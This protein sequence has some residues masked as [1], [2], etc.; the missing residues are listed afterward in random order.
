M[1]EEQDQS[2]KTEEPT[3]KKLEDAHKKGDVVKSREVGHWFMLAAMALAILISAEPVARTLTEVFVGILGNAY[4]IAV[5]RD[6]MLD[7]MAFLM[8]TVAGAF[9]VPVILFITAALG[10]TLVQ[11]K[12]VFTGE[13][14]KPDLSKISPLKGFKR[15]FSSQ[16][17]MEFLKTLAKFIIVASVVALVIAPEAG[18]LEQIAAYDVASLLPL[19]QTTTLKMLVGVLA[20][21]A[22]IAGL[23]YLYQ[24]YQH[25]KK[26]RMTKQ[27]VKDEYKQTDGDPHV[28]ARL[29]QLR[30]ERSRQRMMAA[31][32]EAD[33]VVTNP[34]HFAVAMKYDGETMEAPKV[35]AKGVDHLAARIRELAEANNIPIVENPPLARA[36]YA[37]VE[38]DREIQPEHYRAVA[39]V[40]SYVM[41][42]RRKAR[43]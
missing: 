30:Q 26:M 5:E 19:V 8:I 7:L 25:I 15:L 12:P 33:V 21:M 2:Q 11:H 40:I 38:V 6:S 36:L 10:G 20:I 32:P 22:I 4:Q 39:E 29:R 31:V 3:Q 24:S 42:L 37:S 28:K 18:R 27:E 17:V 16:S 34:T 9:M 35:V 13:R 23:D 14:M 43:Q 1:A 41:R